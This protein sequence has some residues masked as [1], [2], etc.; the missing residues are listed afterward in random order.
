MPGR[1]ASVAKRRSQIIAA[2][3]DVAAAHGLDGLTVRRVAAKAGVSPGLVLFHFQ[4]KDQLVVELLDWLLETTTVLHVSDKIARIPSP[5][6][7][8]LALLQQEMNRLSSEPRRMLVFFD[9]WSRGIRHPGIRAKM[10]RELARYRDAFRPM[11]EEVLLSEPD[12]FEHVTAEGLSAVA[13]SFIKG[14]AVQSMIDS[15]HFDLA[16]YLGAAKG[17]VGQL[18]RH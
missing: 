6:D 10:R 18:A 11:A 12:R 13:V 1:H 4:A 2:A 8:L 16:Q 14:C 7:R 9:F 15:R 17:L 5:L 3:Y